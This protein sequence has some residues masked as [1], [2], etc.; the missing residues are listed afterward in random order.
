[1]CVNSNEI[2][3]ANIEH[4]SI[5][6]KCSAMIQHKRISVRLASPELI[7]QNYIHTYLSISYT[8]SLVFQHKLVA[9]AHIQKSKLFDGWVATT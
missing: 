1:M 3:G 6:K 4:L 5:S 7:R 2:Y 8:I 9:A